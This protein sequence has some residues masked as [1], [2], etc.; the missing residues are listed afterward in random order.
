MLLVAVGVGVVVA[1]VVVVAEVVGAVI[2]LRIT[3][4]QVRHS[5]TTFFL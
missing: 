2:F 3:I 4:S 5:E 1:V